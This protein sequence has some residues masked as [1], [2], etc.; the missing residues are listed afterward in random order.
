MLSTGS[1]R[2]RTSSVWHPSIGPSIVV[3]RSI[4]DSYRASQQQTADRGAADGA[5]DAPCSA[6]CVTQICSAAE[7]DEQLARVPDNVLVVVDFYRCALATRCC[8]VSPSVLCSAIDQRVPLVSYWAVPTAAIQAL[9][10][11]YPA[12]AVCSQLVPMIVHGILL[13]VAGLHVDLA[14]I[15]SRVSPRSVRTVASTTRRCGSPV[16]PAF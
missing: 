3:A 13:L 1:T 2:R 4:L 15:F 9:L 16:D 12:L 10:L 11:G 14:S 6:E 7:F 5:D 8:G